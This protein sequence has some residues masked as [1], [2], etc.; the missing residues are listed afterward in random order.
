MSEFIELKEILINDNIVKFTSDHTS[1]VYL[2]KKKLY[3]IK[4]LLKRTTELC[5]KVKD[6]GC[7]VS[8]K[9][10]T[11]LFIKDN[12]DLY[13]KEKQEY[14]HNFGMVKCYAEWITSKPLPVGTVDNEE[15]NTMYDFKSKISKSL[16]RNTVLSKVIRYG[17]RI[18][19][20]EQ[21]LLDG[22]FTYSK[23]VF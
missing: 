12:I 7:K 14:L 1:Y 17:K 23:I 21:M 20:L 3:D 9:N 2:T 16:Y 6:L 19:E 13:E 15:L 5:K 4:D 22:D 8:H 11:R 10:K 18:E